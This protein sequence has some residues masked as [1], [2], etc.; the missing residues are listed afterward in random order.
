MT[1]PQYKYCD[2]YNITLNGTE[3]GH[4][5]VY[6]TRSKTLYYFVAGMQAEIASD[7]TC[8]QANYIVDVWEQAQ[9]DSTDLLPSEEILANQ[10]KT[11]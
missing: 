5:A 8:I 6:N 1:Y 4:D 3:V 2:E 11:L 9:W 7:V 10:E